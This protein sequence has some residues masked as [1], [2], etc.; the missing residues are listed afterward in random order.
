MSDERHYNEAEIAKIF[1][2]ATEAQTSGTARPVGAEGMTL[3]QLQEI[4][5]DVGIPA[6]LV[7]E[8]AARLDRP[9]PVPAPARRFLGLPLGVGR[10][11]ELGRRLTDDEWER[12]VADLRETFDARGTVL[13]EGSLRQWVNGN[14]H[15][16][17][18]PSD[19]GH[20]L[21][22][23]TMN[24]Q[25]LALM[26]MGAMFTGMSAFLAVALAIKGK[27]GA[28]LFLPGMM[29]LGGLAAAAF[30]ALR[31]PGWARLRSRQM[32]AIAARLLARIEDDA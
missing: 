9:L 3:A 14:L 15:V 20:R 21:R 26:G 10:T 12:L 16:M 8:A 25:S 30:G 17:L 27:V 4:G 11:V 7:A 6:E 2:T 29:A 1:E 13:Q 18:E 19:S 23:R 22:F 24:G 32:E 28:E 31:L 5:H